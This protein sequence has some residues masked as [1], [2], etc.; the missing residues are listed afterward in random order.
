[1]GTLKLEQ[2]LTLRAYKKP[3]QA[4]VA[5]TQFD[6]KLDPPENLAID[7]Y[8]EDEGSR[9]NVADA[10]V[11]Q[12]MS[13][14]SVALAKVLIFQPDQ[15]INVKIV[16]ANGTTP[17]MVFKGGRTTVLHMEFTGIKLSN[18]SGAAVTGRFFAMGD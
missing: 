14:G 8:N 10:T 12:D 9:Y 4:G 6:F 16:N 3:T 15:D 1:M 2:T 18:S 11:D 7:D 13:L 5:I 17:D